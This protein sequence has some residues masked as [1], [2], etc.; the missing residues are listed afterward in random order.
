MPYALSI[1]TGTYAAG[2]DASETRSAANACLGFHEA[3]IAGM[4]S[5]HPSKNRWTT[6]ALTVTASMRIVGTTPEMNA[7]PRTSPSAKLCRPRNAVVAASIRCGSVRMNGP[8]SKSQAM[9]APAASPANETAVATTGSSNRERCTRT[10]AIAWDTPKNASTPARK[11]QLASRCCMTSPRSAYRR[12]AA[13]G[14][15]PNPTA[16]TARSVI[17][18]PSSWSLHR[19][20]GADL[21]D[22]R[23]HQ[24][25]N[26]G[27]HHEA[28]DDPERKARRR[29]RD[30]F[31][32]HDHEAEHAALEVT[33]DPASELVL[34]GLGGGREVRPDDRVDRRRDRDVREVV[35]LEVGVQ[36]RGGQGRRDHVVRLR[37]QREGVGHRVFLRDAN[38]DRGAGLHRETIGAEA[39]VLGRHVHEGLPS[40]YDHEAEHAALEVTAD[41]ASELVLAGLGGGR[42]VRP[43]DRVDRRRDRDVREVVVLEVGVQL[44]GGQ[45][46]RDHVVRLRGQREGVGHRVFLRDA[47]VDRGAGLHRETIGAEANVLGRHVHEG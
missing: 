37:G 18:N 33:A 42:E 19:A 29:R 6:V 11:P 44:R 5:M 40:L 31:L 12:I 22:G 30:G 10:A 34:A 36:L 14:I 32:R 35:V 9:P 24:N 21:V 41:P 8:R 47:D 2:M 15:T 26:K 3:Q 25:D 28:G 39:N 46:R 20:D 23:E 1:Q 17:A 13:K 38:V 45:G 16:R 4:T 27:R 43:D 7:V